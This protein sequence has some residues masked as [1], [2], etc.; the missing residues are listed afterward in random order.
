[1]VRRLDAGEQTIPLVGE[2]VEGFTLEG[3]TESAV[4]GGILCHRNSGFAFINASLYWWA[5][6]VYGDLS[7]SSKFDHHSPRI[8]VTALF[9]MLGCFSLT[10]GLC[11]LQNKRKAF[12]GRCKCALSAAGSDSVSSESMLRHGSRIAEATSGRVHKSP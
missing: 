8:F 6:L 5:R 7:A 2:G 3:G 1:M 12:I 10:T 11:C 9:S 4:P